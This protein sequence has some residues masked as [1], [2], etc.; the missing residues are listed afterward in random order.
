MVKNPPACA[1]DKRASGSIPALGRSPG[2]E[3]WQPTPVFLLEESHG[4]KSLAS[5]KEPGGVA[6]SQTRLKRLST[7]CTSLQIAVHCC[8]P[9]KR[10]CHS[11]FGVATKVS[12]SL[13]V[14]RKY[15]KAE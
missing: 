11:N 8:Q 15:Q 5:Y 12:V 2:G 13:E 6:K 3:A 1:R 7:H 9:L 4:Q 14:L 10:G